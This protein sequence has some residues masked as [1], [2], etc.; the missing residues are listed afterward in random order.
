M[1]PTFAD[2]TKAMVARCSHEHRW[3]IR[4]VKEQCAET[5]TVL[6]EGILVGDGADVARVTV[7]E[8]LP[9]RGGIRGQTIDTNGRM[10]LVEWPDRISVEVFDDFYE[11]TDAYPAYRFDFDSWFRGP[12]GARETDT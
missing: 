6:A 11:A 10:T 4:W 3:Q 2:R 1:I 5:R 12:H 9:E 7:F 8:R